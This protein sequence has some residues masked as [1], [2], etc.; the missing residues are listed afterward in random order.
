MTVHDDMA[1]KAGEKIF[2]NWR[3]SIDGWTGLVSPN[4]HHS[5]TKATFPSPDKSYW[6]PDNKWNIHCEFKPPTDDKRD[7]IST[8]LGQTLAYLSDNVGGQITY[9]I[10]PLKTGDGYDSGT[11]LKE[12]YLS[13]IYS[14][15]P[16][17]L[18]LYE[19]DNPSN[20][21]M[22]VPVDPTTISGEGDIPSTLDR[23]WAKW[24]DLPTQVLWHI[25]D[26]AFRCPNREA[27][28]GN[29]SKREWIM[30]S[31][32]EQILAPPSIRTL[33]NVDPS[34]FW[35]PSMSGGGNWKTK[36]LLDGSLYP[37]KDMQVGTKIR[38]KSN[39][40][41]SARRLTAEEALENLTKW[42]EETGSNSS[43]YRYIWKNYFLLLDHLNFWDGDCQ[44][45]D[46]GY[47]LHRLG[48]TLGY[49]SQMFIDFFTYYIL[50]NG[51]HL[52]L[53][54]DLDEYTAGKSYSTRREALNGFLNYYG[55]LGYYRFNDNRKTDNT[56]GTE[57]FKY[58]ILLWE[59][60][61][62]L[63]KGGQIYLTAGIDDKGW[64]SNGRGFLFNHRRIAD[65]M[66]LVKA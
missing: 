1:R 18:I 30:N 23:Y 2:Q 45:N 51:S 53:I 58:E 13:K 9:Q 43:R 47:R 15:L 39:Q 33:N 65:L 49:N 21:Q 62:L 17:G 66:S 54:Y 14:K 59:K 42:F 55:D 38:N 37:G 46:D 35:A 41:I 40:D 32:W 34:V 56:G 26:F 27:K 31:L 52:R 28:R 64:H 12:L 50:T 3:N 6:D 20:V 22:A 19:P 7:I 16:M 48:V 4:V 11:F 8:G 5:K 63:S 61:G 60:L 57:A 36:T 29:I 44:L 10:A 25:L 24:Q